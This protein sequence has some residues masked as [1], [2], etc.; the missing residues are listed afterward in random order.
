MISKSG[1]IGTV[2]LV[3]DRNQFSLFESLALLKFDQ[4][5][6]FPSSLS[7]HSLMRALH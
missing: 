5:S 7:M 3:E 1:S 2:A 4:E 6:L